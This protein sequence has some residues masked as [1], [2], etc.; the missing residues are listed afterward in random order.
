MYS[1][2]DFGA[3]ALF[4]CCPMAKGTAAIVKNAAAN[5]NT[6]KIRF[7]MATSI[8]PPDPLGRGNRSAVL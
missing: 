5:K 8:A 3:T 2:T 4:F 6:R 1:L 7:N